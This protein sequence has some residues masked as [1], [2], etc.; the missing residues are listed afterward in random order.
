M[1]L[2]RDVLY[3]TRDLARP[4]TAPNEQLLRINLRRQTVS[5][6]R[7]LHGGLSTPV[8]IGP[9]LWVARTLAH[10]ASSLYRVNPRTLRGRKALQLPNAG[11]LGAVSLTVAGGWLWVGGGGELLRVSPATGKITG[12]VHLGRADS[13]QVM[14]DASDHV[15]LVSTGHGGRGFIQARDP[16][17][18]R[19]VDRSSAF[20]GATNPHIGGSFDHV[21]WI[22]EAGGMAGYL[23]RLAV[24]SLV[25][26][27]VPETLRFATNAVNATIWSGILYV[28]QPAAGPV[29]NYCGDPATGR[30]AAPLPIPAN[31]QLIAA[32][33]TQMYYVTAWLLRRTQHLRTVP[34][35]HACRAVR[36]PG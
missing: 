6:R 30:S 8:V 21:A 31:A 34:I 3:L 25:R 20:S 5:A 16:T 12:A 1:L 4:G 11:F 10:G 29:R 33:H 15:L 14:S 23:T 13:T 35:P 17:T 32:G 24:P 28:T 9:H 7:T 18:G 27:A 22:A 19:L 2:H 26:R 36:G